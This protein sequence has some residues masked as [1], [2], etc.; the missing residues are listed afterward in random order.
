LPPMTPGLLFRPGLSIHPGLL[1]RP[2]YQPGTTNRWR[3]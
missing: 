3:A 2:G 1:F